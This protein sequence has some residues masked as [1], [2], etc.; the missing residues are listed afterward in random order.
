M[1]TKPLISIVIPTYNDCENLI[2]NIKFI[3]SQEFKDFE[4][5]V[6]N[7]CSIDQT[8][9]YLDLLNDKQISSLSLKTNKGPG[10]ARNIGIKL[11]KGDWIS[12]LD[13]DDS[14]NTKRLKIISDY[15]IKNDNLDLVCHNEFEVDKS[16]N[17]KKKL[18]YGPL[19]KI[20]PYKDLLL[21]GN[22]FSTSATII[23]KKFLEENKI[24]FNE[25]RNFFSVEDYDFWL[26]CMKN[27]AKFQF[28]NIFLGNYHIHENN[29][30]KNKF[31]KPFKNNIL[32]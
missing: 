4:I 11:S 18:Y 10:H 12:F 29:I 6:I 21:N 20:N 31:D 23:K 8:K 28:L 24:F 14:W 2:R 5:I 30:T 19:D 32:L 17:I 15:L 3:K 9:K 26:K 7:D 27:M 25:E 13:S 16:N 22:K 1:I